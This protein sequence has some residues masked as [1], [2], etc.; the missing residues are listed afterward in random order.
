MSTE[1]LFTPPPATNGAGLT[2][3]QW[4]HE[5]DRVML[6][7]LGVA[8]GDLADFMSWDMWHDNVS[9]SEAAREC[10]MNDDDLGLYEDLWD[11]D[12]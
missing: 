5:V 10:F 4:M 2:Y 7:K 8:S 6:S 1:D 11:A 3:E 9:P 12:Q